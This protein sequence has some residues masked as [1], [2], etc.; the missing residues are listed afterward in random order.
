MSGNLG[1]TSL[2]RRR[3]RGD[4][5]RLFDGLPQDLRVW[6]TTAALPWSPHSCARI[7]QRAQR[8]GLSPSDTIA[9]LEKSERKALQ[10]ERISRQACST[11]TKGSR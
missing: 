7:W 11:D 4:P 3:R 10:R 5:M 6:M 8:A 2:R 9:R 1:E